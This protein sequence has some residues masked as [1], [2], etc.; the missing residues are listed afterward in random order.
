MAPIILSN[1]TASIHAFPGRRLAH[2]KYPPDVWRKALEE[3]G[4]P[5]RAERILDMALEVAR[6]C[7]IKTRLEPQRPVTASKLRIL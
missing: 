5:E 4:S 6:A 1:R 3:E 7:G 2:H